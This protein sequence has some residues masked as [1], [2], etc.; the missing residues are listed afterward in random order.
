MIRAI[1][2]ATLFVLL[3][4]PLVPRASAAEGGAPDPA[5]RAALQQRIG[6]LD[7]VRILGPGGTTLLLQPVVRDDGLHMRGPW[8]PPRAAI[9]VSA[10]APVPPRPVEFVP[11]SEID[12]VQVHHS[13]ARSGALT[14]AVIGGVV[15]G[16]CLLTYHHQVA[17]EWEGSGHWIMAG[18]GLVIGGTTLT[19]LVLGTFGE[20][21]V[22]VLPPPP[23]RARP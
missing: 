7:R 1:R 15:V 16:L 3:C 21:W 20:D 8:K 14:G 5:Q 17:E 13:G 23:S 22:T 10:D 2:A 19:G 9:F 12:R 4:S 18:S 6:H 11:W